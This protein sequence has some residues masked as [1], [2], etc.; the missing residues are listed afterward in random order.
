MWRF[1]VADHRAG[2]KTIVSPNTGEVYEITRQGTWVPEVDVKYLL[3]LERAVCCGEDGGF[4]YIK[5]F[6]LG[7]P[8][9]EQMAT[10]PKRMPLPKSGG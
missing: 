1:L 2:S 4:I 7:N 5:I 8:T 10:H 3:E 6:S 9:Q